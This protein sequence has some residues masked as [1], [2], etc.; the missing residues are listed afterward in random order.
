ML[1]QVIIH[2]LTA[3]R[4]DQL[5]G[6]HVCIC[7]VRVLQTYQLFVL[8]SVGVNMLVM[9]LHYSLSYFYLSGEPPPSPTP[10]A[11]PVP[12]STST[13]GITLHAYNVVALVVLPS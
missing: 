3:F 6:M 2:V 12:T 4:A 11:M 1:I 13:G 10:V 7:V 5:L 9:W 8:H